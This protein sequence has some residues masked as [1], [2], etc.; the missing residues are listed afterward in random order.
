MIAIEEHT[1][2]F[3]RP[4]TMQEAAGLVPGPEVCPRCHVE[5]WPGVE[6]RE[7]LDALVRCIDDSG[8]EYDNHL[9]EPIGAGL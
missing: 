8:N 6:G 3:H 9:D 4:T 1:I 2:R 5:L 7:R